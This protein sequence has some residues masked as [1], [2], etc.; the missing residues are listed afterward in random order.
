MSTYTYV[1]YNY[2]VLKENKQNKDKNS[3]VHGNHIIIGK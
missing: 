3:L 2:A 1:C